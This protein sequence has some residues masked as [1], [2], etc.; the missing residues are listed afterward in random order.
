ML[1]LGLLGAL[2]TQAAEQRVYLVA[3]MQLDGSSLAQSIFLHEPAITELDGCIEAVR[4]A[5]APVTGRNTTMCSGATGSRGFPATCNTA[6][7]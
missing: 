5:S 6:A 7:P 3:T 1:A 2:T 4:E